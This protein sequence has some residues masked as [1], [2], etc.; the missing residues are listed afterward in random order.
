VSKFPIRLGTGSIS[1]GRVIWSNEFPD[2]VEEVAVI[3]EHVIVITSERCCSVGFQ[4]GTVEWETEIIL[5]VGGN[6]WITGRDPVFRVFIPWNADIMFDITG[7]PVVKRIVPLGESIGPSPRLIPELDTEWFKPNHDLEIGFVN[8]HDYDGENV[9]CTSDGT[10]LLSTHCPSGLTELLIP[11]W[12]GQDLL[13][14]MA[15]GTIARVL[16][17]N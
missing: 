6:G 9:V 5:S 8:D 15:D 4:S 16:L 17:E 10:E 14:S 3:D 11:F 12:N 1:R 7:P 13:I 2:I